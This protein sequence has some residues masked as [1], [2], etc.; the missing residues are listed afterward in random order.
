MSDER[1]KVAAI[2]FEEHSMSTGAKG[3]TEWKVWDC[4]NSKSCPWRRRSSNTRPDVLLKCGKCRLVRYCSKECQ[5]RHRQHHKPICAYIDL[6]QSAE[7]L[8]TEQKASEEGL[9][10]IEKRWQMEKNRLD[11][12]V[13]K[14]VG[15][16]S[17][18]EADGE[19]TMAEKE[20]RRGLGILESSI[21]TLRLKFDEM[22]RI[23]TTCQAG[24]ARC[25]IM[26]E[27]G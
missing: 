15:E 24:L 27:G 11:E 19:L 26:T 22:V 13:R 12:A 8:L 7:Q 18:C 2:H 16:T 17:G 20:G 23:K 21:A 9:I 14:R 3:N 1:P 6:K 4:A 5:K 10:E 25:T